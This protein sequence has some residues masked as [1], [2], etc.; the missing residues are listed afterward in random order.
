M[1]NGFLGKYPREPVALKVGNVS[2]VS[3][4]EADS[5]DVVREGAIV[6]PRVRW[7]EKVIF[8]DSHRGDPF[9]KCNKF[10]GCSSLDNFLGYLYSACPGPS[11]DTSHLVSVQQKK[12]E[13][14]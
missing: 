7:K 11:T 2:A 1:H 8:S 14:K 4:L 9:A 6:L 12:K 13:G 10:G 5:D 3:R